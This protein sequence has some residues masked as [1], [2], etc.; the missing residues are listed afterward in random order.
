MFDYVPTFPHHLVEPP[1]GISYLLG[2]DRL[3]TGNRCRT[4]S[5]DAIF[6]A[7]AKERVVAGLGLLTT[8]SVKADQ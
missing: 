1:C 5:R 3:P 8:W 4:Q 2:G 7:V 6:V